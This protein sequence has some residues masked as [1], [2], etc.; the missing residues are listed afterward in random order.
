[1]RAKDFIAEGKSIRDQIVADVKKHGGD[2][3]DYFVRYTNIDKLGY[4]AKQI[5][6]KTPDVDDPRFDVDYIGVSHGKNALWFYPLKTVL[7]RREVYASENPY[8]W[9][10][11]LKPNAW[12]QTVKRGQ[13]ELE[14]APPD[15]QR[16][17]ILRMSDP[18]AAIFFK[19]AFDV[20]GRYY[21][22]AGRHKRHGQVKGPPKPTL[23]Q[24]IRGER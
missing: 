8:A 6:S 13:S 17:G 3:N 1:M 5:F 20:I 16:V 15:K 9:L 14:P 19:P 22:Y 2:L 4:S 10:V 24:R 11:K 12:L 7:S 21:D 23:F 18:P